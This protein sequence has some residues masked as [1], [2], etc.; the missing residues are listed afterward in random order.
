MTANSYGGL[1]EQWSRSCFCQ[2]K[3]RNPVV[4]W[5][6]PTAPESPRPEMNSG[7]FSF[8]EKSLDRPF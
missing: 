3:G 8:L 6:S 5:W 2:S 7:L 1:E 4:S